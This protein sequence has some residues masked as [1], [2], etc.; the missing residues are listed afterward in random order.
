LVAS[1]GD[2]DIRKKGQTGKASGWQKAAV[3]KTVYPAERAGTK[4]REENVKEV[5]D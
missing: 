4:Y 1:V 2:K 3:N 5:F